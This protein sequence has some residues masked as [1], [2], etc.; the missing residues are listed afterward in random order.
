MV[1]WMRKRL[2]TRITVVTGRTV[3]VRARVRADVYVVFINFKSDARLIPAFD[4]RE[5]SFR[6]EPK[7]ARA[8]THSHFVA[9]ETFLTKDGIPLLII[10]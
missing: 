2:I 10:P 9:T 1:L 4:N 6:F 5:P 8:R 7:R 3:C